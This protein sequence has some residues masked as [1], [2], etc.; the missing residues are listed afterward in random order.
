MGLSVFQHQ[1]R[2]EVLICLHYIT[3]IICN[4][5]NLAELLII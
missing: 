5:I 1:V 3:I 2:D 4:L